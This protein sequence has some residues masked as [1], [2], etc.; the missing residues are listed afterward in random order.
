MRKKFL[1]ILCLVTLSISA[2]SSGISQQDYESMSAEASKLSQEM[3]ELKES[4]K[5]LENEKNS[6]N[7]EYS[8][9]KESMSAYE[10]LSVAEAQAKQIE[11]DT[12]IASKASE[13]AAAAAS[14]AAEEEAAAAAAASQKEA[15]E[16]AG[17]NTGITYDQLARTPEDFKGK[18]V[19]FSG[20]VIQ[21]LE[22][23]GEVQIRFAVN[24]NYDTIIYG[25]YLNNIISSRVLEDD[26]IT[27]YGTSNGL[28]SY[29]ST[30]GGNI[31]IPSVLIDKIDQ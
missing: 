28:L 8:K 6:L 15:E 20:K 25:A 22:G 4:A 7:D 2:C 10:G 30:M 13:E 16:K 24:S 5:A 11:A 1:M 17:Y 9:Y 19:K 14:K 21:V 31:T 3:A 26:K 27:I 12:I 23:T 18:K 29:Q